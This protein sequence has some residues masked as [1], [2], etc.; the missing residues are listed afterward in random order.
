MILPFEESWLDVQ[1]NNL[2]SLIDSLTG[3]GPD[4]GVAPDKSETR[5]ARKMDKQV[6]FKFETKPQV[7]PHTNKKARDHS[8]MQQGQLRSINRTRKGA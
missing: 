7:D 4:K 2:Q 1:T 3:E 5:G 8:P 6:T